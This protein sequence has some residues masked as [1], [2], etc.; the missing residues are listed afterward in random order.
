MKVSDPNLMRTLELAIQF[1]KWVLL[2][3]MGVNIDPSLEP[4]LLQQVIK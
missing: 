4:I 3:N 2:E 1:G